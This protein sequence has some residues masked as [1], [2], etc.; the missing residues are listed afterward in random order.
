MV[1]QILKQLQSVQV[2]K[3]HALEA[4]RTEAQDARQEN[5]LLRSGG[6]GACGIGRDLSHRGQALEIKVQ[7]SQI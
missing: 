6:M 4:A 2:G 5:D 1:W 3:G 7:Q